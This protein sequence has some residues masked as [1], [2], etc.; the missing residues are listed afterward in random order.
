MLEVE[1]GAVTDNDSIALLL[2]QA[3][4]VAG[5]VLPAVVLPHPLNKRHVVPRV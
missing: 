5:A 2:R 4:A 3:P 1:W